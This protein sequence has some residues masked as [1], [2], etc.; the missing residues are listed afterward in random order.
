MIMNK[1]RALVPVLMFIHYNSV[2][3][4]SLARYP[5]I[6]KNQRA[7]V[8][9]LNQEQRNDDNANSKESE[10]DDVNDD[11]NGANNDDIKLENDFDVD[12]EIKDRISLIRQ[13]SPMSSQGDHSSTKNDSDSKEDVAAGAVVPLPEPNTGASHMISEKEEA[14]FRKQER[15]L[16]YELLKGD[17]AVA[18]LRRLWFSERGPE[19]EAQLHVAEACIGKGSPEDWAKAEL[20]LL[21]LVAKDPTFLEPF[22]RLSKLY[23]LQGRFADSHQ[24]CLALVDLCPWHYVLL[25]TMVVNTMVLEHNQDLKSWASKRLPPPSH[26]EKRSAWVKQAIADSIRLEEESSL[27]R[28]EHK[29]RQNGQEDN[30]ESDGSKRSDDNQSQDWQ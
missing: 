19:V 8:F 5:Q 26:T 6:A 3:S 29:R 12:Q 7:S 27:L 15:E 24:I 4:F 30:L 11:V 13:Q 21:G 14:S 9:P 25:E 10:D 18:K 2:S 22:V 23:T 1:F 20:V 17:A 28:M 16:L